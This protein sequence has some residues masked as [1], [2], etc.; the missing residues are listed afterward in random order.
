MNTKYSKRL[1]SRLRG[2]DYRNPG[3]YFVTF[4]TKHFEHLLGKVVNGKM[5]L[6]AEGMLARDFWMQIPE[7]N[8]NVL[9]DEFVIMPNHIH[10]I[11]RIL[12]PL[13]NIE[14]FPYP[15]L[16]YVFEEENENLIDLQEQDVPSSVAFSLSSLLSPAESSSI[17]LS[18]S[19]FLSSALSPSLSSS[20]SS[21]LSVRTLHCNVRTDKE[22]SG[23]SEEKSGSSSQDAIEGSGFS[24]EKAESSSQ[25]ASEL[26]IINSEI[27]DLNF[28]DNQIEFIIELESEMM[29]KLFPKRKKGENIAMSEISP[30]KGSLSAIVRSYKSAVSYSLHMMGIGFSWHGRFYDHI[31]RN[32]EELERIRWYIRM[33]PRNWDDSE[34]KF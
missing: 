27:D 23:F 32:P 2:Y 12:D 10:G 9:L 15:F 22:G 5:L 28:S 29:Q 6:T 33:N 21:S 16:D 8:K 14:G 26:A 20:L 18:H 24:E 1:S 11:L 25:D 13:G 31:V 30:K 4:C 3:Y 7:H 34:R 19:S 17:S